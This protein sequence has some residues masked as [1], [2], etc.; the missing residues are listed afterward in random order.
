MQRDSALET[1]GWAGMNVTVQPRVTRVAARRAKGTRWPM[2][3]E[4]RRTKCGSFPEIDI[5][6]GVR[7]FGSFGGSGVD[8][9]NR[10]YYCQ[11]DGQSIQFEDW[12]VAV[13]NIVTV[14]KIG[15]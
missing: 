13:I 4:G 15:K 12:Q 9:R 8:K 3:A 11:E 2:P 1:V 14:S 6:F 10:Y 7:E 5:F